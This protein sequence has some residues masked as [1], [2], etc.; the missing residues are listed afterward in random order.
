MN[1][2]LPPQ[3]PTPLRVSVI[4]FLRQRAIT[5]RAQFCKKQPGGQTLGV[6]LTVPVQLEIS[7]N[8][9]DIQNLLKSAA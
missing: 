5:A 4:N 1:K 9:A 3:H 2:T 7:I 6:T 8:P